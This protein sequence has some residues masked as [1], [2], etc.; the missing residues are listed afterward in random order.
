MKWCES[1]RN[2]RRLDM[3]FPFVKDI[4]TIDKCAIFIHIANI[5]DAGTLIEMLERS[6]DITRDV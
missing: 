4:E 5:T 6:G 1:R 2:I 3:I